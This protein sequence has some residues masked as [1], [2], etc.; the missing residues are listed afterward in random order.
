[1][2]DYLVNPRRSPRLPA[3]CRVTV[4]HG[5]AGWVAETEDV[6]PRGC[7]IVSPRPLEVGA[8]ARLVIESGRVPGPLTVLGRVAWG[9]GDGRCRAGVA[10]SDRVGNVDPATWFKRLCGLH[11][12]LDAALRRVPDRLPLETA[13]YLRPPPVH[14]FD[15]ARDE[16][17]VLRALGDG[18][19]V[20]E[21]L[22][23]GQMSEAQA[24]RTI[25]ALLERRILT[26]A[27]GE[28][29]PA[30]RWK[31]AIAELEMQGKG[32]RRL[33]P[34]PDPS[35]PRAWVP[36]PV[37]TLL[38]SRAPRP[39]P[40]QAARAYVAEAAAALPA[41]QRSREAQL[42]FD[43]AVTAISAGETSAGVAL[44]R[45]ALALSPRDPEVAALLGQ[46]SLKDPGE[47][48]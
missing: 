34:V 22:R 25:F 48:R 30:W 33:E 6:G 46:V 27:M 42:C 23:R 19:T 44:L 17:R 26:L 21:V 32:L 15:F 29:A 45:R 39:V 11:P 40:A 41:T 10:F 28:A 5:G 13:L 38:L 47:K 35:T 2:N 3:R 36:P 18:T 16:L 24:A 1:M 43:R 7:Q 20:G 4:A 12:E 14:I 8:A 37:E 9:V 31:A